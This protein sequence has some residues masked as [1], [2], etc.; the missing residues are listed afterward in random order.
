[1]AVSRSSRSAISCTRPWCVQVRD[2][3]PH[4]A[5]REL[6][7]DGLERR[8]LLPHDVVQ[9]GGLDPGLL[10]LLIGPP[11]VDGL[12]LPDV[13]DQ[14]HA[15]VRP[16]AIEELV[17]LLRCSPGSIRRA[18]TGASGSVWRLLGPRQMPLQRVRGHAGFG[19]VSARR[20]RSARTLRR[21]SPPAPRAHA[22]RQAP[23]SCRRRRRLRAPRL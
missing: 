4:L 8:I 6:L 5:A 18:R 7:D 13:A 14:Q 3:A 17:H 19:R 11:G 15:V 10:E 16:E 12:M 2:R 23:S 9:A 1:M 22:P 20:V 21:G